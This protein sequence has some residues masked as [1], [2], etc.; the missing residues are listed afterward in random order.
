MQK[1]P[2]R[3]Q[4]VRQVKRWLAALQPHAN[5]H[6]RFREGG[7]FGHY[8]QGLNCFPT[9]AAAI[10]RY[11]AWCQSHKLPPTQSRSM[12]LYW[13]ICEGSGI[14]PPIFRNYSA[15]MI[16]NLVGPTTR[17]LTQDDDE[18]HYRDAWKV[19]VECF[20]DDK[21]YCE[22]HPL[23]DET[24]DEWGEVVTRS[25]GRFFKKHIIIR[26]ETS[27]MFSAERV[28]V[29]NRI[30]FEVDSVSRHDIRAVTQISQHN[31][32]LRDVIDAIMQVTST[33]MPREWQARLQ[34]YS[35]R[36]FKTIRRERDRVWSHRK[37]LMR[38]ALER[39][40][41]DGDAEPAG[42]P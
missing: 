12:C 31:A 14:T 42:F 13:G 16:E 24:Y 25:P 39:S 37:R 11:F 23:R 1:I 38:R 32:A 30:R 9:N 6:H 17:W 26:L 19:V 5:K 28:S 29:F 8:V 35:Y 18:H 27:Q 20:A 36:S 34:R 40:E 15:A 7:Y 41:L 21:E 10:R 2:M 4:D 22:K 33:P 3:R